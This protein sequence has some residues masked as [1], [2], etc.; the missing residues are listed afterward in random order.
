MF[1]FKDL[2]PK[3]CLLEAVL[4]DNARVWSCPPGS[5]RCSWNLPA[6]PTCEFMVVFRI[7]WGA[8]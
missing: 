2:E 7:T 3:P 4:T 1:A 6:G 8:C 5:I